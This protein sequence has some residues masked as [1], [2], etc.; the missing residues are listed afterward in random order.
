MVF[1]FP[2]RTCFLRYGLSLPPKRRDSSSS[3]LPSRDDDAASG[4][5]AASLP[6]T[7]TSGFNEKP[8]GPDTTS[9]AAGTLP[10]N[11]TLFLRRP[12]RASPFSGLAWQVGRNML[13][14]AIKL[15][16]L[17]P[18]FSLIFTQLFVYTHDDH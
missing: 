6:A 2:E 8:S 1:A 5:T 15:G 4:S 7:A 3:Q 10:K 12:V 17:P 9:F 14:C 18:S 13:L 11:L 16:Y